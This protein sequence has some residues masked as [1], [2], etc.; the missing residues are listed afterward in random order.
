MKNI[1]TIW[2]DWPDGDS[3]R[4]QQPVKAENEMKT[5]RDRVSRGHPARQHHRQKQQ[6]R[7]HQ[8]NF[9]RRR[10]NAATSDICRL[11]F[12]E[13]VQS[14]EHVCT[15]YNCIYNKTQSRAEL[16][17]L[18]PSRAELRDCRGWICFGSISLG[19]STIWRVCASV[20]VKANP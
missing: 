11:Q 3:E 9:W 17:W 12:A 20:W 5:G 10:R 1:G 19:N 8:T 2:F 6:Q 18:E 16:S 7:Q 4:R 13:P 15:M 14:R